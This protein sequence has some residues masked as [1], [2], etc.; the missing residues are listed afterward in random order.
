MK[1]EDVLSKPIEE[2]IEIF[3]WVEKNDV[4]L[5]LL[6][7]WKPEL[8]Q[9]VVNKTRY[10]DRQRMVKEGETTF[11][12]GKKVTTPPV[13]EDEPINRI[14]LQIEQE[15]VNTHTYFTVG[16]EPA[17]EC[18][19]TDEGEEK[20]LDIIYDLFTVNKIKYKNKK[21]VRSWLSQTMVAEYWYYDEDDNFFKSMFNKYGLSNPPRGGFKSVVW[22]PFN[23]D[24]LYPLFDEFGKMLAFGRA[25]TKIINNEEV[26][27][28]TIITDSKIYEYDNVDE[29]ELVNETAH[30]FGKVPVIYGERDEALAENIRPLRER[31]EAICSKYADSIDYN[32]LPYLL[33]F[34]QVSNPE[35]A[36]KSRIINMDNKDADAKYLQWTQLPETIRLEMT[37]ITSQIYSLTNTPRISFESMQNLSTPP[38][39]T[40]FKLMFMGVHGA[41]ENHAEVLGEFFQRRVNLVI[42][43]LGNVIK[44]LKGA[45]ETITVIS[46][47]IP[48]M[49]DDTYN[50]VKTAKEAVEGK[51][52]S[53]RE[54]VEYCND[55]DDIEEEYNR[56]LKENEINVDKSLEVKE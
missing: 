4:A 21:I 38:S 18:T 56:I 51:V 12:N 35:A 13:F 8:H 44:S 17:L 16:T 33:L 9:I 49:I 15:I 3:K 11:I 1:I 30:T 34:G 26:D 37:N 53:I 31:L 42:S 55:T 14:S 2:Q 32:F 22:S 46:E 29:W 6:N 45:S 47:I 36:I 39:G 19:P 41:V 20:L 23:G 5:S 27:S 24:R 48:Y 25:F 40:A 52:W 10:P 43:G 50:R 54:A 7:D 28:F